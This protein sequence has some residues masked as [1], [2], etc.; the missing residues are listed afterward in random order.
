MAEP[1]ELVEGDEG[2][3]ECREGKM[4]VDAPFVADSRAVEAGEPGQDLF[5]DS[6]V[7]AQALPPLDPAPRDA[8][9]DPAYPAFSAAAAMI[10]SFVAV[11]LVRFAARTTSSA[12][13]HRGDRVQR[14]S[15]LC[16]VVGVGLG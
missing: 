1:S 12:R 9:H 6:A 8:E 16:S 13:R 10:V 14:D 7:T 4:D 15:Q 5:H 11:Q 2:A 3:R